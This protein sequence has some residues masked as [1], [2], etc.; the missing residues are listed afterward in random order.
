MTKSWMTDR[1]KRPTARQKS[2]ARALRRNLTEPEKRLWWH[3][4]NRMVLEEGHFRRQVAIGPYIADF[5][6]LSS[7]LIIEVDGNQHGFERNAV[8]DDHRTEYLSRYSF[9]VVRFTNQDVMTAIDS[10]LDTI[11]AALD[12]TTAPISSKCRPEPKAGTV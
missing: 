1:S 5:C 3:I 10:V 4:R 6:H 8:H 11:R 2:R 7:K 12:A 9:R